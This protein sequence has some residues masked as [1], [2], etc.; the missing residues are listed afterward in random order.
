MI[1]LLSCGLCLF[2][3]FSNGKSSFFYYHIKSLYYFF[4][5]YRY[6]PIVYACTTTI[7]YR[8][9]PEDLINSSKLHSG[10]GYSRCIQYALATPPHP[11]A[12]RLSFTTVSP[13]SLGRAFKVNERVDPPFAVSFLRREYPFPP[14]APS[15]DAASCTQS[16]YLR[17]VVAAAL[18]AG[19]HPRFLIASA[20]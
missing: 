19:A 7:V 17:A 8:W 10:E 15:W 12:I 9:L 18:S 3:I 2:P 11:P 14:F 4:D 1:W 5:L 13:F 6:L 20:Y 16:V